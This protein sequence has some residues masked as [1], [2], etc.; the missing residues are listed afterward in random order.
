MDNLPQISLKDIEETIRDF[1]KDKH[2]PLDPPLDERVLEGY[3]YRLV[4]ENN[5]MLMTGS[6]G[7]RLFIEQ[8]RQSGR[9]D[10]TIAGMITIHL[11]GRYYSLRQLTPSTTET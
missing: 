2:Q 3:T 5:R 6:G 7:V 1:F 8:C 4:G 10:Y 11:N 9:S